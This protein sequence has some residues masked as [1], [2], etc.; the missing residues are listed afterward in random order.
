MVTLGDVLFETDRAT[1]TTEGLAR[2]SEIAA[3]LQANPGEAVVI[4]GHADARGASAYN[5]ALSER[6]AET[7]ASVLL[8]QGIATPR[9]VYTGLGEDS[10]I[11][12]N[13]TPFGQSLNRR[14]EVVFVDRG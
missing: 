11:A 13:D 12:S 6:R 5:Q 9:L 3:Y 2:V 14:V 7:V 1:L 4:E 8:A 10:P